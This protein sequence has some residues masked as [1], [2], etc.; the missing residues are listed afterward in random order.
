M[1][2]VAESKLK[3]YVDVKVM[4]AVV[5]A[6]GGDCVPRRSQSGTGDSTTA[7]GDADEVPEYD[8][9]LTS[10][11]ASSRHSPSTL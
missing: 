7:T 8:S 10:T 4:E 9:H 1:H 2:S 3:C 6:T 11:V 5:A